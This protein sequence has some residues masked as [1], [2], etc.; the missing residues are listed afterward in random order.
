MAELN[1][2]GGS[3]SYNI[4][5]SFCSDS[6]ITDKG[7]GNTFLNACGATTVNI[8]SNKATVTLNAD[9]EFDFNDCEL[10]D[11]ATYEF[12]VG[13][14]IEDTVTGNIVNDVVTIVWTVND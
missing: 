9:L 4:T 5:Q 7:L 8:T 11:V 13:F 2:S 12:R 10:Q 6:D 14:E 1:V 3:G